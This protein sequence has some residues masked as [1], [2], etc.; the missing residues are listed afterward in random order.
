MAVMRDYLDKRSTS[1][2][3]INQ[4]LDFLVSK[5]GGIEEMV[6]R[7]DLIDGRLKSTENVTQSLF[8]IIETAQR[9][10]DTRT[11]VVLKDAE[12]LRG[13]VRDATTAFQQAQEAQNSDW[14]ERVQA[15]R[16]DLERVMAALDKRDSETAVVTTARIGR[17]ERVTIALIT[18]LGTL[19]GMI[20]TQL[21]QQT[22]TH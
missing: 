15:L 1:Q 11:V 3:A 13:T 6:H 14:D 18:L 22:I 8:Q 10:F 19:A 17:S 5:L 9:E 21:L 12:M 20:I 7:I 16:R 2:L 4:R